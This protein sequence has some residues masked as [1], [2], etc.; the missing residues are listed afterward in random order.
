MKGGKGRREKKGSGED[1]V[2]RETRHG[3]WHTKGRRKRKCDNKEEKR[4]K[5]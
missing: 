2:G 1:K 4:N 3:Q 5:T